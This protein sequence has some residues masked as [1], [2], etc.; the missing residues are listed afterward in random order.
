MSEFE[1]DTG[2]ARDLTLGALEL[3]YT[4]IIQSGAARGRPALDIDVADCV[5]YRAVT[6]AIANLTRGLVVV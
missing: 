4:L 3:D 1:V 5:D 2:G 6:A